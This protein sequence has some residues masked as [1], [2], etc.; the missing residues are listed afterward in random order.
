MK[1]LAREYLKPRKQAKG[2]TSVALVAV[3]ATERIQR[4]DKS[5]RR[6]KKTEA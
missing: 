6:R 2:L 1:R 5:K 4:I 3:K